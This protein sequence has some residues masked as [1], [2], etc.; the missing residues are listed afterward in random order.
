[1]Q[2]KAVNTFTPAQERLQ[3]SLVRL[4]KAERCCRLKSTPV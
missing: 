2:F 3:L 1:M 4:T